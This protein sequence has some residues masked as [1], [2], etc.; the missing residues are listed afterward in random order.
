MGVEARQVMCA[1]LVEPLAFQLAAEVYWQVGAVKVRVLPLLAVVNKEMVLAA[2][3]YQ[4]Y[5]RLLLT[6]F[7]SEEQ[8]FASTVKAPPKG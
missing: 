4:E 2:V 8:S 6:V 1:S 5:V 7:G 3:S